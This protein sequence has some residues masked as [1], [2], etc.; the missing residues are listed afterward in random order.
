MGDGPESDGIPPDAPVDEEYG[1]RGS[2]G[3]GASGIAYSL[4]RRLGWGTMAE[5]RVGT[6]DGTGR[7][8]AVKLLHPH[9]HDDE[10][11]RTRFHR[12]AA[13]LRTI[14]NRHVVKLLDTVRDPLTDALILEYLPD[15]S[16]A[17]RLRRVGRLDESTVIEVGVQL[18]SAL[19]AIHRHGIV[20][21]D[22][23]PSNVLL[24]G[25]R[26]VLVDLGIAG[27]V[28]V[29][30][31][32]ASGAMGSAPYLAPEQV[33]GE[34]I[35]QR[36][37]LFALGALLFESATGQAPFEAGTLTETLLARLHR[38]APRADEV[39]PHVSSTLAGV[40]LRCLDRAPERRYQ[41]AADL[42]HAL[43]QCREGTVEQTVDPP[44]TADPEHRGIRRRQPTPDRL[45]SLSGK[46]P[47]GRHDRTGQR[48][49]RRSRSRR[50]PRVR[51]DHTTGGPVVQRKR[52]V[53]LLGLIVTLTAIGAALVLVVGLVLA[54]NRNRVT[55]TTT[56]LAPR[57]V[58]V[59][60]LEVS[61]F[62]PEGDNG[63]EREA[64][65]PKAIDGDL[66]SSWS[67]EQY[68]QADFGVKSGVGLVLS[69]PTVERF[70]RMDIVGSAGWSGSVVA[71]DE[72][73]GAAPAPDAGVAFGPTRARTRVDLGDLS[74]RYLLVWIERLS[75]AAR[76]PGR[77][78]ATIDELDVT[79]RRP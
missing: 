44:P 33:A 62:D 64:D 39:N 42:R 11:I 45:A 14:S 15:G 73:P 61:S 37:D 6:E 2:I 19:E 27:D 20:H 7:P 10:P 17:D 18:A 13:T 71:L 12:E 74:G 35:D 50:R 22:L 68:F 32:V 47:E 38:D 8:V 1:R 70:D 46:G 75:P 79:V 9:L 72:P 49:P 54:G 53:R 51:S 63:R 48:V 55:E 69:F 59:R 43:E 41:R 25:E 21:R 78:D 34:R 52:T 57:A 24:D 58:S 60:P 40:L 76:A 28:E 30:A 67:T 5:V 31:T 26:A 36:A 16:L 56:T 29:D 77:F 65:T 66:R 23:K 3:P 4:G